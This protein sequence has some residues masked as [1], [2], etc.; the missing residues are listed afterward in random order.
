MNNQN[1]YDYS[2]DIWSLGC[3]LYE[4]VVGQPPFRCPVEAQTLEV[5][6]KDYFSKSFKD[7]LE[8]LLMKNPSRRITL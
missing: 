7:L 2:V 4:I 5:R 6:Y 1:G 3:C 8:G